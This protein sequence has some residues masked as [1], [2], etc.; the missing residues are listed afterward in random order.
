M[1]VKTASIEMRRTHPGAVLV[2]TQAVG[3]WVAVAAVGAEVQM[4]H[5]VMEQSGPGK[6]A[7]AVLPGQILGLVAVAVALLLSD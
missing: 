6:M 7:G 1:M 2:A 5:K 4:A 3:R